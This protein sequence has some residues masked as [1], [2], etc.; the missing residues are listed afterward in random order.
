MLRQNAWGF[1]LH[2][3]QLRRA[4]KGQ[5]YPGWQRGLP[6]DG[7]PDG[8]RAKVMTGDDND[9]DDDDGGGAV[10]AGWG[11]GDF[12]VD[13]YSTVA[14]KLVFVLFSGFGILIM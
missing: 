8:D 9:D 3:G 1:N 13:E 7:Y 5:G 2:T 12:D 4:S 14:A 10:L 11:G 6:P